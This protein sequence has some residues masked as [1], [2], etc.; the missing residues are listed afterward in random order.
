MD[1]SRTLEDPF[2]DYSLLMR[3]LMQQLIDWAPEN[4]AE[5]VVMCK[6]A[7]SLPQ[8]LGLKKR[9]FGVAESYFLCYYTERL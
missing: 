2:Q 3:K 6:R 8:V 9:R 5:G 7:H 1:S 4:A